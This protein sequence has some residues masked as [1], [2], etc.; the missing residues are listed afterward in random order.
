MVSTYH[1]DTKHYLRRMNLT[2]P[3]NFIAQKL[4][5]LW[6]KTDVILAGDSQ[7]KRNKTIYVLESRAW[8]DLLVLEKECKALHLKRPLSRIRHPLLKN[9][10]SVYSVAQ[11]QPLMAWLLQ[12]T[13]RSSM[14]NNIYQVLI[15]TPEI[16]IHFV[17]V[18]IFLGPTST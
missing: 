8:S 15:D 7:V 3:F 10:H 17:P 1:L 4:L 14:L 5:Y 6:I 13:K 2:A 16:D 18:I 12:E 9:H 11:T